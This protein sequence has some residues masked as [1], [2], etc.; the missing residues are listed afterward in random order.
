[1]ETA[2]Q[3]LIRRIERNKQYIPTELKEELLEKERQQIIE[4]HNEGIWIDGKAFDEGEEY[5]NKIYKCA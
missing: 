3:E 5:Y 2:M 4:A 1:M